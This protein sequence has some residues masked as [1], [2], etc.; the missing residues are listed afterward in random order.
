ML[1]LHNVNCKA[2]LFEFIFILLFLFEFEDPAIHVVRDKIFSS[3]KPRTKVE[4]QMPN[5]L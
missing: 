3:T 4:N 5:G 1:I 2:N